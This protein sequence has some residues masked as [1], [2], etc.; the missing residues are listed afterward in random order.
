[1]STPA[2]KPPITTS[3]P[4]AWVKDNL[5]GTLSNSIITIVMLALLAMVIPPI[6]EW[7][8]INAV[9]V[10]DNAACRAGA[11]ACWG[12]ISEKHQL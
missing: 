10:A 6:I 12:F 7:V 2:M 9:W 5:F 3:G 11:G 4:I 8:F 1:M